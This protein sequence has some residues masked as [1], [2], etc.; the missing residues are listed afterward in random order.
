MPW[1]ILVQLYALRLEII[2]APVPERPAIHKLTG[3]LK[4]KSHMFY[5]ENFHEY[6]EPS[7]HGKIMQIKAELAQENDV[8]QV[9]GEARGRYENA[10]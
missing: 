5:P 1:E 9:K 8:P 3:S 2:S 4:E 6:K 10:G 7:P